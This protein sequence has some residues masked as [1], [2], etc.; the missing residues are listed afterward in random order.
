MKRDEFRT[1]VKE[2]I[3]E[4]VTEM[5]NGSAEDDGNPT[6]VSGK[7]DKAWRGKMRWKEKNI[8]KDADLQAKLAASRA[9]DSRSDP[10]S[11]K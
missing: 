11:D 9:A 1:M 5:D 7:T 10:R 6:P 8:D 3:K 4:V 2:I